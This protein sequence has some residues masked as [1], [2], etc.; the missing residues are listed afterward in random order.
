MTFNELLTQYNEQVITFDELVTAACALTWTVKAEDDTEVD[1]FGANHPADIYNAV[2]E[3]KLT[4]E[5]RR[6]LLDT[7][8]PN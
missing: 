4:V 6:T 7:V 2:T 3:G 5:E 8:F 1:W